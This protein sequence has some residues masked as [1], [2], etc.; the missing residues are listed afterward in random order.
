[1]Q[2][3]T[4]GKLYGIFWKGDFDNYYIGHQA[5]EILK[6]RLY[7]PYLE[8]KTDPVV[9][10]C[11]GN[12]GLFS[13]YASKYA[14][15]VYTLE[16][17]PIHFDTI[18]RML[19]FNDIRN[20]KPIN[21]AIYINNGFFNFYH[22]INETMGSLHQAVADGSKPPIQVPSITLEQLFK[23]EKID[24]CDLLKIDIEGTEYE[25]IC[26]ESFKAVADKIDTVIG[27]THAWADRNPQQLINALQ[28]AGF[29]YHTIPNDAS[30]FVATKPQTLGTKY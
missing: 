29:I 15:K 16:P 21:K 7:A 10:D 27:E 18:N 9:I 8:T 19:A 11:G 24:H 12:I 22:N 20:V 26:S 2:K 3:P 5:E 6:G 13:L 23:D 4:E 14:K 25:V 17:S 30:I 1:M 28:D